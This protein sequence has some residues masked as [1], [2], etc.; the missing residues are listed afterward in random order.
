MGNQALINTHNFTPAQ[1]A[2][3]LDFANAEAGSKKNLAYQAINAQFNGLM[4]HIKEKYGKA[5]YRFA[6][7]LM[8][9]N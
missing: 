8:D 9:Q 7:N 3:L 5:A 4:Q 2:V 6:G 1:Q